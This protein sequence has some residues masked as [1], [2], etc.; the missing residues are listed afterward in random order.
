MPGKQLVFEAER[1]TIG[2]FLGKV[3]KD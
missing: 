2:G 3:C 1:P